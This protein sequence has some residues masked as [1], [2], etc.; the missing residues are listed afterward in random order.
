M[1]ALTPVQLD[2]KRETLPHNTAAL[3]GLDDKRRQRTGMLGRRDCQGVAHR[4]HLSFNAVGQGKGDRR[5]APIDAGEI[6]DES[7]DE[8]DAGSQHGVG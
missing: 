5:S 7:V 2:S 1:G 8:L 4:L 6:V 3:P